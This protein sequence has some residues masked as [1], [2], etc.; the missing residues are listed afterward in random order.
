MPD[1]KVREVEIVDDIYGPH[2]KYADLCQ[3][4]QKVKSDCTLKTSKRKNAQLPDI[5][6]KIKNG[7]GNSLST[8]IK[9]KVVRGNCKLNKKML[10]SQHKKHTLN[11][12]GNSSSKDFMKQRNSNL[13]Y[14]DTST[15]FN[16]L[17]AKKN[18]LTG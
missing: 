10:R 6:P 4:L 18:S 8:Q 12:K 11:V 16:K 1:M 14:P 5:S 15:D 13:L 3:R 7:L 9:K 17:F 2:F